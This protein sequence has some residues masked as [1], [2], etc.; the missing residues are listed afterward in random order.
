DRGDERLER[1]GRER[2][3]KAVQPAHSLR[4]DRI[5]VREGV[6]RLEIELETEQLAHDGLDHVVER[7]DLHA[8]VRRRDPD[9]PP[10]DDA[11]KP[12]VVKD[13]R[14]ID[15][16]EREAVERAREVVRLRYADETHEAP[17]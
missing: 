7:L 17:G 5:A 15:A 10:G 6:E 11:V 4:E 16:P 8:A 2:R 12:S 9:L 14:T 3:A 13:V 1:I